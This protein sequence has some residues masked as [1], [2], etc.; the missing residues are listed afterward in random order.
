MTRWEEAPR[1]RAARILAASLGRG[2]P[3]TAAAWGSGNEEFRVQPMAAIMYC[4]RQPA[5]AALNVRG[6]AYGRWSTNVLG[7]AG[8]G[9]RHSSKPAVNQTVTAER[10]ET[11][12]G[13]RL[14]CRRSAFSASMRA[15]RPLLR[16]QRTRGMAKKPTAYACARCSSQ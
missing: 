14:A 5:A 15:L 16:S 3:S 13:S 4:K 10:T 1:A 9:S 11:A 12:T 2:A 6:L 7:Q 8:H